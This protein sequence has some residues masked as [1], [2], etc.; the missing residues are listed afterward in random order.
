LCDSS[1]FRIEAND[2]AAVQRL[3]GGHGFVAGPGINIYNQHSLQLLARLGM[4]RWVM[5]VEL[6]RDTLAELQHHRPAGVE[7]EIFAFGRLPLATSARCFTAHHHRLPKDD[8]QFRCL[9]YPA[10]LRA[11]TLED[12]P[13]LTING[14]QLQS[15]YS[16]NL[17]GEVG[18][19][20]ELGVDIVRLSPLPEHMDEVIH[21]FRQCLD[22]TL[23]PDQGKAAVTRLLDG[24]VCDGYWHGQAGIELRL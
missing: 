11:D 3:K 7:T 6:S 20:A 4:V 19:M 21:T 12:E 14:V 2:M 5:P 10:G 17:A 22:G 13:F 15:A 16:Y 1:G 8:C 23:A 9:D 24:E 18:A